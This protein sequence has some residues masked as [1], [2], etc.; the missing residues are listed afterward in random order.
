MPKNRSRNISQEIKAFIARVRPAEW[1]TDFPTHVDLDEL[2]QNPDV[3]ANLRLWRTQNGNLKAYAFVHFPYNNLNFEIDP[4]YWTIALEEE[5]LAW[6]DGRMQEQ[7]GEHAAQQVLDCT[8]RAEDTR[9]AAFLCR[10]GFEKQALESLSYLIDLSAP[11]PAPLLPP[12]FTLRPLDPETE[13]GAAVDLFQAAYNTG[14][15][16]LEERQAI[17][18]TESYLP[19]LDIVA[20]SPKGRLVGNCICGIDQPLSGNAGLEGF[21]DPLVVHPEFQRM[22]L[23]AALL[24]HGLER[25]RL[26]G[27]ERVHLGTSSANTGMRRAAEKAG[28]RC[29]AR[30]AWYSKKQRK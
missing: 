24:Q 22:G 19:D 21:T 29:V 4:A 30:R 17:M 20:L 15:F 1:K 28:F 8:C 12:G 14:N 5:I 18:N 10:A 16:T 6:A 27:V 7:Y 11:L 3:T 23:A 25:L 2:F 13:T 9:K 26:R